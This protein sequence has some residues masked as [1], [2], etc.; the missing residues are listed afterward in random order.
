MNVLIVAL[1]CL[2]FALLIVAAACKDHAACK[3][4]ERNEVEK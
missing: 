1:A 2:P 4:E 3:P